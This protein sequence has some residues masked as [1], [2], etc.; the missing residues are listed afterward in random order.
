VRNVFDDD[1]FDG[2]EIADS[3]RRSEQRTYQECYEEWIASLSP[4]DRANLKAV[5]LD[6]PESDS[7]KIGRTSESIDDEILR[8]EDI[9]DH[10]SRAGLHLLTE[11]LSIIANSGNRDLYTACC[12]SALQAPGYDDMTLEQIGA[13]FG[14]SKQRAGKVRTFFTD[15]F[16]LPPPERGRDIKRRAIESEQRRCQQ[17]SVNRLQSRLT[18]STKQSRSLAGSC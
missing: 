13:K 12:L 16:K 11:I 6:R 1:I 3:W 8:P 7:R 4:S 10:A 18:P 17:N 2:D 15:I 9:A 5:G 14:V